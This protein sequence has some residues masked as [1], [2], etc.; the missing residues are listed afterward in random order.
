MP[1]SLESRRR[2]RGQATLGVRSAMAT[3]ATIRPHTSPDHDTG[4]ARTVATRGD[5]EVIAAEPRQ[6][7]RSADVPVSDHPAGVPHARAPGEGELGSH[8]STPDRSCC[9][10]TND[11]QQPTCRRAIRSCPRADE[12]ISA[13]E[14]TC[15]AGPEPCRRAGRTGAPRRS[16]RPR[17]ASSA[18][19][20]RQARAPAADC[21]GGR[22]GRA[23]ATLDTWIRPMRRRSIRSTRR[24]SREKDR[25]MAASFSL[26]VTSRRQRRSGERAGATPRR[27]GRAPADR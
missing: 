9:W 11:R 15:R 13:N 8:R 21:R 25:S 7:Q 24:S 12:R 10:R 2:R 1:A 19:A 6:V 23:P 4:P 17:A 3:S 18:G 16:R 26:P 20:L 22:T 14:A 5:L 27:G